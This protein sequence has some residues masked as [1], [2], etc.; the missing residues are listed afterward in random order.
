[1]TS[2]RVVHGCILGL[3]FGEK[4]HQSLWLQ[5][6]LYGRNR[7][8]F[9]TFASRSD[10]PRFLIADDDAVVRRN[11]RAL[12]TNQSDWNVSEADT[13]INA[14]EKARAEK[15]DAVLL[16]LLMPSGNGLMAAYQIRQIAPET[17]IL[18]L[19]DQCGPEQASALAHLFGSGE[20]VPKADLKTHLIASVKRL[21]YGPAET[22]PERGILPGAPPTERKMKMHSK[23]A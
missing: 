5:Q 16:D 19:T 18:F 11:V 3:Q 23:S 14:V 21:L 17:K 9:L 13:G 20:Y 4:I 1:L 10:M 8:N 2:F 15:P 7:A 22:A 12:L 6:I